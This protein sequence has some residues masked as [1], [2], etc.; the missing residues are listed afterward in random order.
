MKK[1]AKKAVAALKKL[2]ELITGTGGESGSSFE[3]MNPSCKCGNKSCECENKKEEVKVFEKPKVQKAK[4]VQ[5]TI[6]ITTIKP[7]AVSKPVVKPTAKKI[8]HKPV[9]NKP[10]PK[11]K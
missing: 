9:L 7:K 5:K 10:K 6:K 11:K 4:P 1:F 2:K 8:T 3:I